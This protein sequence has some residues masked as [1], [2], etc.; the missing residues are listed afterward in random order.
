M[1][2]L[3][4][5]HATHGQRIN[6]HPLHKI[7]WRFARLLGIKWHHQSGVNTG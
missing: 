2:I 3:A 1:K 6:E 7:N 4:N 5:D